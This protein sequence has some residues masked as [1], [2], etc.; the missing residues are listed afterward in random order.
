[1]DTFIIGFSTKKWI[2]NLLLNIKT[3]NVEILPKKAI[4]FGFTHNN[5]RMP[6]NVIVYFDDFTPSQNLRLS[7]C[8]LQGTNQALLLT[9]STFF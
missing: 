6:K 4:F 3:G 1:M 2:G 7:V 8:E 5:C 9:A